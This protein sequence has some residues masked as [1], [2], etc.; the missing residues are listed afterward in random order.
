MY[1]SDISSIFRDMLEVRP[2]PNTQPSIPLMTVWGEAEC[3]P[4]SLEY[5]D[6]R[7]R[8]TP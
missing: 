5:K 4:Y 2:L 1:L 8:S 7:E 6:V 3:E